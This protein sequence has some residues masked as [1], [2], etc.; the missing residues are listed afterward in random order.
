M[1]FLAAAENFLQARPKDEE[2]SKDEQ[3]RECFLRR[4]RPLVASRRPNRLL[5]G[6]PRCYSLVE[7]VREEPWPGS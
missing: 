3:T 2:G 6:R 4:V 7:D 1:E 5:P